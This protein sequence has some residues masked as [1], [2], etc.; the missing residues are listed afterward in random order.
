MPG[1]QSIVQLFV[2]HY[3]RY[4]YR[5]APRPAVIRVRRY[6][7]RACRRTVSLLPEL[8]LLYLRSSLIVI[9][10]FLVARLLYGQT[11]EAAARSAP[12]PMSYQPGQVWIRRFRVQAEA[13]CAPLA[14]LTKP[15]PASELPIRKCW[16]ARALARRIN[17][18]GLAVRVR[19]LCGHREHRRDSVSAQGSA[20]S[21]LG[22]RARGCTESVQLAPRRRG[23]AWRTCVEGHEAQTGKSSPAPYALTTPY[24]AWPVILCPLIASDLLMGRN[25]CPVAT[26]VL[27]R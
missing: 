9:A 22:R 7:C 1:G 6:L 13:V 11:I 25:T 12:P 27:A 10:L 15:T 21:S 26:F 18:F 17:G 20:L 4:R 3:T 5:V 2:G 24:T 8:I 19:G 14:E 23:R 16:R